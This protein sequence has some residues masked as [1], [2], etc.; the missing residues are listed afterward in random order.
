MEVVNRELQR[1]ARVAKLFLNV[2][3]FIIIG[4]VMPT[5]MVAGVLAPPKADKTQCLLTFSACAALLSEIS[6]WT[7]RMGLSLEASLQPRYVTGLVLAGHS[8][9]ARGRE[10]GEAIRVAGH[11]AQ[12]VRD[13]AAN[14]PA[15]CS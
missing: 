3:R 4:R 1:R 9:G 15:L 12:R 7:R 13:V 10:R 14:P 11:G 2:V 5:L 6:P 8:S